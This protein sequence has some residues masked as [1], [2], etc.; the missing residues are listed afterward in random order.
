MGK[1]EM[2]G[3]SDASS[4]PEDYV[5]NKGNPLNEK[6]IRKIKEQKKK[7]REGKQLTY[8]DGTKEDA[9]QTFV[10]KNKNAERDGNAPPIQY[11]TNK[12][13]NLKNKTVVDENAV[14]GGKLLAK[15]TDAYVVKRGG[16]AI[17]VHD[18]GTGTEIS[19]KDMDSGV[20]F[21]RAEK[22]EGKKEQNTSN[23]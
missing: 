5:D 18:M 12:K 21:V 14:E 22:L 15:R 10:F 6:E 17:K 19:G 20:T 9:N 23:P 1:S 4:D 2:N 11:S 16:I 8:I 7:D 13:Q 3:E